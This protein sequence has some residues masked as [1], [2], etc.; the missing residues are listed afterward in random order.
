MQNHEIRLRKDV[1][2]LRFI[3][4]FGWLRITSLGTLMK[5]HTAT[6]LEAGS[7][8]ARS[9]I[10]RQLVLARRLPEGA[11]QA[12]VLAAAGVRL[13]AEYD[14]HAVSGKSIGQT[15]GKE[16]TPST[17][18]KH[19]ILA[20]GVLCELFKLGYAVMPEAEIRRRV[21]ILAKL[22]DGLARSPDGTWLWLEVENARKS[23][24]HMRRL[25]DAIAA[26]SGN[27]VEICGVRPSRCLIAYWEHCQDER[28]YRVN[29]RERI[30]KAIAAQARND[31]QLTFAECTRKGAA[32]ISKIE[33]SEATVPADHTSAV[34]KRLNANGWNPDEK[35]G[36]C[37]ANYG[38]CTAYVWQDPD[39]PGTWSYDA[40]R[41]GEG[42]GQAGY[43]GS[44]S[45]AKRRAAELIANQKANP[46]S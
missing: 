42:F 7:R 39:A 3:H 41:D 34:L 4:L 30:T 44:I 25:A 45:E 31:I 2:A 43:A 1:A 38:N 15:V 14:I 26:V 13:L 36:V 33:F 37:K 29:H 11:G 24:P 10:S 9:L 8:L 17:T 40:E 19:D 46:F 16:W 23:G 5:P 12:L 22:P 18:W 27:Q 20:H 28:G 6:S 35:S 32:G 21:G